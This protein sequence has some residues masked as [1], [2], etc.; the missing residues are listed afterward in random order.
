[1]QVW[2]IPFDTL[3]LN[4]FSDSPW[5]YGYP[6]IML[7][8]MWII[9]A[10]SNFA[11]QYCRFCTLIPALKCQSSIIW[12]NWFFSQK[13]LR[14][15]SHRC[16]CWVGC[17]SYHQWTNS[18]SHCLWP[19]QERQQ[20]KGAECPHFRLGRWYIWCVSSHYWGGYLWSQINSWRHSLRWRRFWQSPCQPLHTGMFH[21]TRICFPGPEMHCQ[22]QNQLG[23][24]NI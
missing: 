22:I 16:Y 17:A 24:G 15:P 7:F 8:R 10:E 18:S 2:A 23:C 9:S 4:F 5:K 3:L 13:Q 21:A 14:N 6:G 19:G 1:M 20:W 11:K 12:D